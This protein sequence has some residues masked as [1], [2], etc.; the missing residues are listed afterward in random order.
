MND[1][2]PK[3]CS[4]GPFVLGGGRFERHASK[5]ESGGAG[6]WRRILI[7]DV[8]L[9]TRKGRWEGVVQDEGRFGVLVVSK[10]RYHNVGHFVSCSAGKRQ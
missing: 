1:K 3:D 8:H 7:G 6:D 9:Q 10:N 4:K 2:G 5:L